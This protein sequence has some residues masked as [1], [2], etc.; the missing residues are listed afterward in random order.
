MKRITTVIVLTSML[1]SGAAVAKDG[2]GKTLGEMLSEL[3]IKDVWTWFTQLNDTAPVQQ[4]QFIANNIRMTVDANGS[5]NVRLE[6]S[7]NAAV[8]TQVNGGSQVQIINKAPLSKWFKIQLASGQTGYIH[9]SLL[10]A[11]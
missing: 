10:V 6:P 11:E 9:Q 2:W 3:P 4:Q 5:V 8:V 7:T 1:F